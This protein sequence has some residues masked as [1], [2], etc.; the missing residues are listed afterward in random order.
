ML[1]LRFLSALALFIGLSVVPALHATTVG[2]ARM[3]V[4][5][6]ANPDEQ[7]Q[8]LKELHA[9]V[10]YAAELALA[11]LWDRIVPQQA[12]ADVPAGM[13]A[14]RFMQR[15]QPTADGVRISFHAR[16]VMDYLETHNIPLIPEQPAWNLDIRMRNAAGRNMAQSAALI[17]EFA[18]Q[19]AP[20]WGYA[21]SRMG[22]SL[23]VQWRWLDSRQ[24][25]L[26]LRGTS[27]LGEFQETRMLAPGDPLP[28]LQ[29]WLL[30]TLLKARDAYATGIAPEVATPDVPATPSPPVFDIYGNPLVSTDIYTAPFA[31]VYGDPYANTAPAAPLIAD[32]GILIRVE[33]QASLP[34]QVLFEQDLRQDPRILDLSL[35]RVN[36]DARQYRLHLKGADD[37]WL[38]D[39]FSRRG[40]HL[41]PTIE[42]WVARPEMPAR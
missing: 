35:R 6:T 30:E 38:R 21:L 15:A 32:H 23:I 41:A 12:R 8:S 20:L 19:Q 11:Q 22:D 13:R 18:A 2:D 36:R 4:E 10:R 33:R 34:E 39:W 40:L 37:L 26:S 7:G 3:L 24:V 1:R 28:Q 27:R 31:D 42:G 5:V 9:N 16:R 17:S 29:Q 25:S 14:I